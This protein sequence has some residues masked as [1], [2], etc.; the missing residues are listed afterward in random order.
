MV[1]YEIFHRDSDS[2]PLQP[3]V[4]GLRS[5]FASPVPE[6]STTITTY[7]LM[8][9]WLTEALSIIR[10]LC[11]AAADDEEGDGDDISE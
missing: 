5:G 6:F 11:A 4:G 10:N 9:A 3:W 7:W 1:I 2:E 8:E